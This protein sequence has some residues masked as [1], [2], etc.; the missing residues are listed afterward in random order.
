[1]GT[2]EKSNTEY[3]FVPFSFNLQCGEEGIFPLVLQREDQKEKQPAR[4]DTVVS[5]RAGI[6]C[7]VVACTAAFLT[8]QWEVQPKLTAVSLN[9]GSGAGTLSHGHHLAFKDL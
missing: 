3:H 4:D 2:R 7:L 8:E 1:M 6:Q 5:G 9:S